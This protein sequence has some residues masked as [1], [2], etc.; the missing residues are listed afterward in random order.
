MEGQEFSC[1]VTGCSVKIPALAIEIQ[2]IYF[3]THTRDA[4]GGLGGSNAGRSTDSSTRSQKLERPIIP[5]D[6]SDNQWS[7]FLDKWEDFK[8]FYKLSTKAEIYS[9]LRSCCSDG[10]Q[11]KLYAATGG[12]AKSMNEVDL[13]KELKRLAVIK[14]NVA[15]KGGVW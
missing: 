12:T 14:V 11:Y 7:F 9:H 15:V 5:D 3:E 1:P 4:H 8:L 13:L 10:L 2:K 6:C